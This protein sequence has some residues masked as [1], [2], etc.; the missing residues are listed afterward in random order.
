M[1]MT[2]KLNPKQVSETVVQEQVAELPVLP[3]KFIP[4]RDL[5]TF[6]AEVAVVEGDLVYHFY[7]TQEVNDGPN[8]QRYWHDIF[9]AVLEKTAQEYF[10]ASF[11]RLRAAYTEEK[12]SWWMRCAGFGMLLEPQKMALAFC[13]VLDQAL[14]RE[15]QTSR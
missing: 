12:A 13:D 10:K 5:T 2:T 15:M 3:I 4:V 1:T 9:P 8:P 14:E 6:D 7:V 11:P